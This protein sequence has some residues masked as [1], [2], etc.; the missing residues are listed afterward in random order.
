M[1][2]YPAELC[3]WGAV[4]PM[5]SQPHDVADATAGYENR[6]VVIVDGRGARPAHTSQESQKE[7]NSSRRVL[8]L[9]LKAF[10]PEGSSPGGR[11]FRLGDP[12]L[13][14]R[15]IWSPDRRRR[16]RVRKALEARTLGAEQPST[17]GCLPVASPCGKE[18]LLRTGEI[19]FNS[20]ARRRSHCTGPSHQ[21]SIPHSRE[22]HGR[23]N[24]VA[25]RL[26]VISRSTSWIVDC[27]C[28]ATPT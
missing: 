4:N 24:C 3:L 11:D 1:Q 20:T 2:I 21:R 7:H 9:H 23:K 27:K 19:P 6:S 28:Q 18:A 14:S 12:G 13:E 26:S 5:G 8:G 17:K 16:G 15:A 10:L 25:K 22:P